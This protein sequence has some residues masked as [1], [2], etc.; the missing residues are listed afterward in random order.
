MSRSDF[1]PEP[2]FF[3]RLLATQAPPDRRQLMIG[4]AP[5]VLEGIPESLLAAVDH[6]FL[7]FTLPEEQ[8]DALRLRLRRACVPHFLDPAVDPLRRCEQRF[9]DGR[10]YVYGQNFAGWFDRRG[11]EGLLAHCRAGWH[12]LRV[13]LEI[14]LRV[15]CAWRLAEVGGLLLHAAGIVRDG[16]AYIF[17]GHSGAGKTTVSRLSGDAEF[18]LSDDI[19]LLTRDAGGYMAHSVPF[20]GP[21]RERQVSERRSYPV[22]GLF[23]LVKARRVHLERLPLARAAAAVLSCVPFVTDRL[24]PG[25]TAGVMAQVRTAL[26]DIPVFQMEF[27]RSAEFWKAVLAVEV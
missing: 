4:P 24:L 22:A 17:F 5:I 19:S 25:D 26:R 3:D 13:P 18:L 27:T 15:C 16:R 9:H 7:G 1:L 12:G 11:A 6:H 20:R 10:V 2:A 23:Q 21:L 8:P 14:F